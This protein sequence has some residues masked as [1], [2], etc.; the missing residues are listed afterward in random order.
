[1][2]IIKLGNIVSGIIEILTLGWGHDLA[3]WVAN[4]FGYQDCKCE[5]RRVWLNQLLGC[6]EKSIQL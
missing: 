3:Q 2:C 1:M 4:K 6:K 5:Y